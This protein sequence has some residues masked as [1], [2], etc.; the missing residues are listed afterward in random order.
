MTFVSYFART[1][2]LFKCFCHAEVQK[3]ITI[4]NANQCFAENKTN[5]KSNR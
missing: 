2:H 5:L 3:I 1:L 4:I